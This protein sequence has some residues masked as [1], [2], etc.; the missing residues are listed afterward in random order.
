M[1]GS[2]WHDQ[3][4]RGA[5]PASARVLGAGGGNHDR[6]VGGAQGIP[7]GER[8]LIAVGTM[9]VTHPRRAVQARAHRIDE[10]HGTSVG[11]DRPQRKPRVERAPQPVE[12]DA[13]LPAQRVLAGA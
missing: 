8:R 6:A 13:A 1:R 4:I 9:H 10:V 7:A 2:R 5:P 3:A 12:A 11:I